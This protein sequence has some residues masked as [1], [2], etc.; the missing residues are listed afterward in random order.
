[1]GIF[2][3]LGGRVATRAGARTMLL[4]RLRART[5]LTLAIPLLYA[6][7]RASVRWPARARVRDRRVLGARLRRPQRAIVPD[8][9]GEDERLIGK[10]AAVFQASNRLTILLGPV[11]GG[12]L[13][14][15]VGATTRA[16]HRRRD[17]SRLDRARLAL[18]PEDPPDEQTRPGSTT[19]S[20]ARSFIWRERLLR[21]WTLGMLVIELCWQAL[22]VAVPF[23]VYADYDRNAHLVG[24]IFGGFGAGAIV[25]SVIAFRLLDRS[26][27]C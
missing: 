25:G 6:A 12:V 3:I 8:V 18:R 14:G 26:S 13:I 1:M 4:V 9:I 7:R 2:G 10:A 24:Y 11:L 22:F 21:A 23:L 19:S 16:L 20:P 15:V 5:A 17:L 27:R